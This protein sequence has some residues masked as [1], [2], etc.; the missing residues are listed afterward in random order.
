MGEGVTGRQLSAL[1]IARREE[2]E[3]RVRETLAEGRT[4]LEGR[5]GVSAVTVWRWLTEL[6]I[7]R[8]GRGGVRVGAGRPKKDSNGV[9]Q[10]ISGDV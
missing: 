10:S 7:V 2:W 1:R 6:G 9:N 3:A 8:R 5:L 4:G